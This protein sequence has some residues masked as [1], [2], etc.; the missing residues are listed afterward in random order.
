MHHR[1]KAK[2]QQCLLLVYRRLT[3][4]GTKASS[5]TLCYAQIKFAVG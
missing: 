2:H 5:T 4:N 3:K 1:Y